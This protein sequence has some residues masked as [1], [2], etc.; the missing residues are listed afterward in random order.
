MARTEKVASSMKHD[1]G[2]QLREEV[3]RCL[4][5]TEDPT[6]TLNKCEQGA[7]KSLQL[8][9]GLVIL[10]PTKALPPWS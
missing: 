4:D 9:E 6:P 7:I 1:E 3:R 10:P 8:V 2:Q 5:R